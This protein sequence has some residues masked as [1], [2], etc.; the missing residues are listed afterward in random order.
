MVEFTPFTTMQGVAV[1]VI[2]SI[3]NYHIDSFMTRNVQAC[4]GKE[5]KVDGWISSVCV[6]GNV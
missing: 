5:M 6:T 1:F 3:S 4:L 2:F